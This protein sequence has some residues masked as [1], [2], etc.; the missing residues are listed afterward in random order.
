MASVMAINPIKDGFECLKQS[1]VCFPTLSTRIVI[2]IFIA[3]S[4]HQFHDMFDKNAD[5]FAR[6]GR[7][8]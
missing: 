7:S 3:N 6:E 1:S 8:S 2:I 5:F 4:F